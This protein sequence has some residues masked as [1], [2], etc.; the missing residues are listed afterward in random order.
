LYEK[1]RKWWEQRKNQAV[2]ETPQAPEKPASAV[3][4]VAKVEFGSLKKLCEAAEEIK[5][6]LMRGENA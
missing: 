5:A 2:V 1:A 3:L 6:E 4:P